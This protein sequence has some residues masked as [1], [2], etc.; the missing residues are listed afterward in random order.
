M[1]VVDAPRARSP[2]K[3]VTV[4]S[5]VVH[6]PDGETADSENESIANG[7]VTWT[8]RAVLGPMFLTVSVYSTGS[9]VRP[10]VTVVLLVISRSA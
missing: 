9:P 8:F 3:Q 4:A 6:E 7:S 2:S 10:S 5:A 1:I